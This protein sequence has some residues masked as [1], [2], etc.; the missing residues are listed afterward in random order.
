[1]FLLSQYIAG[2]AA[3][4][5][6]FLNQVGSVP[7][8]FDRLITDYEPMMKTLGDKDDLD[9]FVFL[10]SGS[11][12]GLA[13]E[14]MLKMK[15]VSLSVA[16]AFHFMEFRHGPKSMV[17]PR[18]LVIGLISDN[19]RQYELAVLN[20]MHALG[21]TLLVLD[22]TDPGLKTDYVV[23]FHSG[24]RS[25]TRGSLF[26]PALQLLAYYRSIRKGLNPDQPKNLDAVVRI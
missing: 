5:N 18:T 4:D 21:A 6:E 9:H 25:I 17:T 24:L 1:M 23:E 11:N 16:E 12:Y 19:A 13:C 22:D 3:N 8:N 26:L 7:V 15:E 2:I 20:E 10:G 14:A